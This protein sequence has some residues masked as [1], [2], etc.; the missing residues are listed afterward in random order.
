MKGMCRGKQRLFKAFYGAMIDMQKYVHVYCVHLDGFGDT[1][2]LLNHAHNPC[3]KYV[4]HLGTI[5]PTLLIYFYVYV[6]R[7]LHR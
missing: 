7:T 6:M 1:R 5:P 4:H 3:H 2:T